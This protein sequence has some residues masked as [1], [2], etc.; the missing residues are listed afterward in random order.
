[1]RARGG[2]E[3]GVGGGDGGMGKSRFSDFFFRWG[4]W[5]QGILGGMDGGGGRAGPDVIKTAFPF[6][7]GAGGGG[8]DG[9]ATGGG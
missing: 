3:V 9:A 1:V 6:C 4:G 7:R 2:G 5:T 8:G